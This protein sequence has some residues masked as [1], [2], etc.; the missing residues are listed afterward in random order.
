MGLNC[1]F[2][3]TLHKR[4]HCLKSADRGGNGRSLLCSVL[5]G[6]GSDLL[7]SWASAGRMDL[8]GER[9]LR[10]LATCMSTWLG[11]AVQSKCNVSIHYREIE[12]FPVLLWPLTLGWQSRNGNVM[13]SAMPCQG[14]SQSCGGI[15][16]VHWEK[17]FG[18]LPPSLIWII[19]QNVTI[20]CKE[21]QEEKHWLKVTG[22]NTENILNLPLTHL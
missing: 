21:G 17:L 7:H 18:N 1:G 20:S 5:S 3:A 8:G 16:S 19:A 11:A 13:S 2:A 9:Q 14:Y 12:G 4:Y 22:Q 6:S 15:T 10:S